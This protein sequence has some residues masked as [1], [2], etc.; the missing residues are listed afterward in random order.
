MSGNL[1]SRV[2]RL[3]VL[4]P[5][6]ARRREGVPVA[7]VMEFAGYASEAELF[8]DIELAKMI[9]VPPEAPDDFVEI[10]LDCGRIFVALPLVFGKPPRLSVVEGASLLVAAEALREHSGETLEHALA[11][12]RSAMPPGCAESAEQ[13]ARCAA[14][15]TGPAPR[16]H[17]E[18]NE[19]IAQRREVELDY[20]ALS[21]GEAAARR[22]E[23][24]A[25]ILHHGHWYLA[26]DVVGLGEEHLYRLDRISG[27]RLGE[28]SFDPKPPTASERFWRGPEADLEIEVRFSEAIA[29][30]VVDTYGE[31][32]R[33]NSDGSVT[34]VTKVVG[35]A[36]ALSW[37]LGFGGEAQVVRPDSLRQRL[38]GR[39]E[40]LSRVY[41]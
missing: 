1:V 16:W 21:R 38:A 34:V 29:G 32:A 31:L 8:G 18:L 5:F 11:K 22:V 40:E 4:I 39:V 25:L 37:V 35:E 27:V 36:Y 33:R 2:K 19:A 10:Y 20:W 9:G 14:L 41:S 15:E 28:R 3:L 13:L 17:A 30:L 6:V 26:A 23:P 12:L 24:R 7:E